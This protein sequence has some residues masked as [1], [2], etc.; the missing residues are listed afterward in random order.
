[1]MSKFLCY[2]MCALAILYGVAMAEERDFP[3]AQLDEMESRT[4]RPFFNALKNGNV[5]IVRHYITGE[6]YEE[7]RLLLEENS[8]YPKFLR[9]YYKDAVFSVER[10]VSSNNQVIIDFSIEFPGGEKRVVQFVLEEL[11]SKSENLGQQKA[12][13]KRWRISKQPSNRVR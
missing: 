12:A 11:E 8:E 2:V 1:M 6:M 4:L 10:G 7:S 13:E 5:E 3:Q 9:E